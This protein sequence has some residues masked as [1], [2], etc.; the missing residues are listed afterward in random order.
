MITVWKNSA[1]WYM[2]DVEAKVLVVEAPL[3]VKRSC[4]KYMAYRSS[5]AFLKLADWALKQD[6]DLILTD[7]DVFFTGDCKGVFDLK[8][9]FACT[10]RDAHC[11]VNAGVIFVRNSKEGKKILRNIIE[12]TK[13]II[14]RPGKYKDILKRYLGADQGA[15]A[16]LAD[17]YKSILRLPCA[18]W[19]CEQ[20]SWN[21]FSEETKI[22]HVKS[23]LG[24][25]VRGE[26][27]GCEYGDD[28]NIYKIYDMWKK[29]LE[30][31]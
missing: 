15:L 26:P 1:K 12:L 5:Y 31:K 29:F 28:H 3:D 20:H 27:M 8:F 7:A 22:V 18:V 24:F 23:D 19:N 25:L 9:E 17:R 16:V 2:P 21:V 14:K 6:D 13:D 11:W 30:V 10:V 4:D